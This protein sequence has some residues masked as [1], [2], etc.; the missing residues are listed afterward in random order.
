M[1]LDLIRLHQ[2]YLL[3]RNLS[4]DPQMSDQER[5]HCYAIGLLIRDACGDPAATWQKLDLRINHA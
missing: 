2:A 3:A 1:H 4:Q 5:V